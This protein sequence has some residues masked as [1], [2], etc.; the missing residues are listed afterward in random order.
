VPTSSP[1]P[2]LT[3]HHT[4]GG[5]LYTS[6]PSPTPTPTPGPIELDLNAWSVVLQPGADPIELDPTNTVRIN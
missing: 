2:Q 3:G 1:Y 6:N 4:T 5:P